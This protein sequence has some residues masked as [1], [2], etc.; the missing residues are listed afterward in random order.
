MYTDSDGY[1][2]EKGSLQFMSGAMIV[3][4]ALLILSGVGTAAGIILVGAGIGSIVGGEVSEALGSSYALGWAIG[5]IAG[6][7]GAYFAAPAIGGFLSSSFSLG[8]SVNL[9]GVLS[10]VSVSCAQIAG[11][12]GAV[13]G[14][15]IMMMASTE[16]PG[17]NRAQNEQIS[18]ILRELGLGNNP[19]ARDIVHRAIK[20][21][22]LGYKALK[23]FI[24]NLLGL[25]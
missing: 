24:I 23:E 25:K 2:S 5:G 1:L 18:S 15:D 12:I 16:R 9:G 21:Y 4:G 20:G 7:V 3:V 8:F 17:N 11:T 14:I 22:N 6:A 10:V 19:S 13:I